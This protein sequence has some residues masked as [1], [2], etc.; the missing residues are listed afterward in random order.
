VDKSS[1]TSGF[2]IHLTFGLLA[3]GAL[4]TFSVLDFM[5]GNGQF[6]KKPKEVV[7]EEK[8]PPETRETE[9]DGES[10]GGCCFAI[11]VIF[12]ILGAIAMMAVFRIID[13]DCC[14]R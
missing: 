10:D 9:E 13:R 7:Q 1:K 12:L 5:A 3:L 14:P 2:D 11:M 8:E 6:D 4:A